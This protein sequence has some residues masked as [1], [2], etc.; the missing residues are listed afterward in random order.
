MLTPNGTPTLPRTVATPTADANRR[1]KQLARFDW[2]RILF[3]LMQAFS[4]L[5]V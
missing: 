1:G 2:K 4:G 5:A 3:A